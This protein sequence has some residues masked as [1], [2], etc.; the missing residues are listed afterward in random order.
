MNYALT[1][2]SRIAAKSVMMSKRNVLKNISNF[3]NRAATKASL[4]PNI[5]ATGFCGM[6]IEVTWVSGTV[7]RSKTTKVM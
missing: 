4:S 3:A 7:D 5:S 6:V 2:K 1:G